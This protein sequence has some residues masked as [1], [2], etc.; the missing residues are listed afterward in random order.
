METKV[1]LL[2]IVRNTSNLNSPAGACQEIINLRKKYGSWRPIMPKLTLS[3]NFTA[4]NNIVFIH[5]MDTNSYFIIYNPGDGTIKARNTTS[6]YAAVETLKTISAKPASIKFD[7]LGYYLIASDLVNYTKYIFR[8][9]PELIPKYKDVS[10]IPSIELTLEPSETEIT[11]SYL[12]KKDN[13]SFQASWWL[14]EEYFRSLNAE[15]FEGYVFLR[16]AIE[17][18]DGTVLKH[19]RPIFMYVGNVTST[20]D[21]E[22][23][24]IEATLVQVEY[25]IQASLPS[26]WSNYSDLIRGIS[27][28]MSKPVSK[29]DLE[30]SGFTEGGTYL[31]LE[32][33][34][35][36]V[37]DLFRSE[38]LFYRVH[39]IPYNKI[40]G[41]GTGIVG[42]SKPIVTA[43]SGSARRTDAISSGRNVSVGGSAT[44]HR[45]SPSELSSSAYL[46]SVYS[47]QQARVIKENPA[48]F[49]ITDITSYEILSADDVS[50][51]TLIGFNSLNYNNRLFFGDIYTR[52]YD[53]YNI[54]DI[55][56][57]AGGGAL[58]AF[59]LYIEVDLATE[60]GIKTVRQSLAWAEDSI[61]VPYILAYPDIRAKEIRIIHNSG[62]TFKTTFALESHPVLNLAFA[63]KK[64]GA[65]L[66]TA[67]KDSTGFMTITIASITTA[68]SLATLST[69]MRDKNR[70]QLTE[71]YNPFVHPAGNSYQ[72][73][74]GN[75]EFMAVNMLPL[76]DRFG[77]FPVFVFS[78]RGVWA[79]NISD[80]GSIV[81]SNITPV[82]SSVCINSN[83]VIVVD[84]LLLFLASDGIKLLTGQTP[85]EI[86]DIAEGPYTSVLAGNT[87]YGLL[88]AH[89][90][91]NVVT[92][93]IS[94]V[95]ILA[96][97]ENAKFA[98]D[99]NL[100]EIIVSN[101]SY[102]YSYIYSIDEK[103]WYKCSQ[104]FRQFIPNYPNIFALSIGND[105]VDISQES[106]TGNIAVF[107]ETKP[108]LIGPDKEVKLS[109][110]V[111]GG[112]FDMATSF[113]GVL[114]VYGS[115][116][117]VTWSLIQGKEIT[118]QYIYNIKLP[119][120]PLS[121]RYIVLVFS[122]T[123]TRDSSISE[124]RIER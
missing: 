97:A 76:E 114:H 18:I 85:A 24:T 67:A 9:S 36:L 22:Y 34:P 112:R 89:A 20:L 44:G 124:Y 75:I 3:S 55:I 65:D 48:L 5:T 77:T 103:L 2:G 120:M 66:D 100:R 6:P 121:L 115:N 69:S 47:A 119:R 28:F 40:I 35:N 113:Y 72:V 12:A 16:Y 73:G 84:N 57:T 63:T 51:Q 74:E 21:T 58:T 59:T 14:L 37:V 1:N 42:S 80:T 99:K 50:H 49:N 106:T 61:K 19:S 45:E 101:Y 79:L 62:G 52:I 96:Y 116:D 93:Q 54:S 38:S 81:V 33:K 31:G 23:A 98:Y 87:E 107:V 117:S 25:T 91:I 29:Y 27:I 123:I 111:L 7:S 41:G 118:G 83:S 11:L 60:Y 32:E 110:I 8:C 108:I 78:S 122:G 109:K 53:G 68:A 94:S 102:Q 70:V 56:K 30:K 104:R 4:T 88:K 43:G 71:L 64:D 82:S 105:L 15:Y 26:D 17:L 39:H 86:S 92:N 13:D 10:N 95:D 90:S 46:S